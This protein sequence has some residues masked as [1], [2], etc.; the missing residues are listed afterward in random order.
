MA[1]PLVLTAVL[2]LAVVVPEAV[3]E[4]QQPETRPPSSTLLTVTVPDAEAQLKLD[5][6]PISGAGTTRTV[7]IERAVR[8]QRVVLAVTWKPN[9]YTVLYRTASLTLAPGE[10]RRVDLT[11]PREDDRAEV[12]YVP[13]P[14]SVA[15]RM[16]DLAG[17][18][19]DDVVYELGCG[20][21]R[22]LIA[23]VREGGA[24][25]G[26]GIDIQPELVAR[27]RENAEKEG[28]AD[29]T[30]FRVGDVFDD[31]VTRGLNEA[32]VVMLYMSDELDLL[33][34]PKLLK[35]LKPGARIVSHRFLMGD[36]KP[37]KSETF[38]DSDSEYTVHLWVV[39]GKKDR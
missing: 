30:E 21:G 14:W 4:R 26:V 23:S 3:H 39:G 12:I 17:I 35:N 29:R 5:G 18:T 15:M 1:L 2:S 27:A 16:V 8:G 34:R 11:A 36:W 31:S 38:F 32:T 6:A 22:I 7:I 9:L 25:R 20:E 33:L 13:T 37:D 19:H 28:V 10:T 24:K